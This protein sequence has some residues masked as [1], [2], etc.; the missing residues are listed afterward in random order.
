MT[1]AAQIEMVVNYEEGDIMPTLMEAT[2]NLTTI[3]PS[4]IEQYYMHDGL[5]TADG[6]KVLTNLLVQGLLV[7]L[8]HAHANGYRDE[9]EHMRYIIDQL[10]RGFVEANVET[11]TTTFNT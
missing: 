7:N 2:A 6:S 3:K 9:S 10:Q 4:S 8:K 11:E 1:F 5:P